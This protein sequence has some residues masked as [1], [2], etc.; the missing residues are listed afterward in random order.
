MKLRCHL[1][2]C[3]AVLA[4]LILAGTPWPAPA[5][6]ARPGPENLAE[7][8]EFDRKL[9]PVCREAEM[10]IQEVL[11]EYPGR[12]VVS[13]R[14]IDEVPHLFRQYRVDIVPTQV[15]VDPAGREVFRHEGVFPKDQLIRKLKELKFI[16]NGKQ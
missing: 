3:A 15:F 8:L 9:C 4:A 13:K 5:R 11:G 12:F 10:I 1:R 6:T 7:I 2:I 16:P 14:Y